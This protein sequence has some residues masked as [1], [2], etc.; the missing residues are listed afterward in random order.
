MQVVIQRLRTLHNVEA[1]DYVE[2]AAQR[3]QYPKRPLS[4]DLNDGR[5]M[6]EGAVTEAI[7]SHMPISDPVAAR[8]ANICISQ[9]ASYGF[10]EWQVVDLLKQLQQNGVCIHSY[11]DR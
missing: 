5:G 8:A 11:V 7:S 3:V 2:A 6:N 10:A 9:V 4:L 1:E